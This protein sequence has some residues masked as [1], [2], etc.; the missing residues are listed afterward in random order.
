MRNEQSE[1]SCDCTDE[2]CEKDEGE[3]GNL[4]IENPIFRVRDYHHREPLFAFAHPL[5][6]R[7][8]KPDPCPPQPKA[9]AL[10]ELVFELLILGNSQRRPPRLTSTLQYY[11]RTNVA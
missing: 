5:Q 6:E 7:L 9:E 4:E 10:G 8:E 11:Y 3:E 1:S 2:A